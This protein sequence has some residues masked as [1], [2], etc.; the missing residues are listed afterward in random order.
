MPKVLW[1]QR[2][3]FGPS[4]RVNSRAAFDSKRGRVVLFGGQSDDPNEGVQG[5]LGDTWEWD[6]F[7]LDPGERH[8][9]TRTRAACHGL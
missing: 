8:W 5:I 3:N 6:G 9:S 2:A 4:R 1:T 7:V